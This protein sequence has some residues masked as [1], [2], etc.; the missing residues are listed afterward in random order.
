MDEVHGR[1]ACE[2]HLHSAWNAILPFIAV[3]PDLWNGHMENLL[4]EGLFDVQ[5][6]HSL[7]KVISDATWMNISY[8]DI[9]VSGPDEREPTWLEHRHPILH[10]APPGPTVHHD[11]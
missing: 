11:R 6:D 7:E 5:G 8:S 9:I 10:L 3:D 1:V 4:C 2:V